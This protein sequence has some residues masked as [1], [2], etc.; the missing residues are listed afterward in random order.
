MRHVSACFLAAMSLARPA[1][2]DDVPAPLPAPQWTAHVVLNADCTVALQSHAE[3]ES[4]WTTVCTAPCD[5]ELPLDADYRVAGE[6]LRTSG[7]LRLAALRGERLTLEVHPVSQRKHTT[8]AVLLG[9]GIVLFVIGDAMSDV[10]LALEASQYV[11][12]QPPPRLAHELI[13]P[14]IAIAAVG[15]VSFA[16]GGVLF[17]QTRVPTSVSQTSVPVEPTPVPPVREL[18]VARLPVWVLPRVV[19]MPVFSGSF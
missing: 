19:G 15:L 17:L 18:E 9:T 13:W 7:T 16:T 14:G 2:A 3:G 4:H 12:K 5:R 11:D 6:H 8:G 1:R 10:Y